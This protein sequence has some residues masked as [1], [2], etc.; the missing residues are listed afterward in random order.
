[1]HAYATTNAITG[2]A[3]A[4][5]SWN[6][7]YSPSTAEKTA[8]RD[9]KL[10][11]RL[12]SGSASAN[13]LYLV[14]DF[15]SATSIAGVAVLNHQLA[16]GGWTAPRITIEADTAGSFAT[17]VTA[18]AAT[19]LALTRHGLQ[20]KD[21]WLAFPAVSKRY[22]RLK[23]DEAGG[24]VDTRQVEIG[25]L[26]FV[27]SPT[28]LTRMETYGGRRDLEY[29][30]NEVKLD[31]G[32]VHST[33]RGG[34]LVTRRFSFAELK[35]TEKDEVLAMWH[36]TRGGTT[37]LLWAEENNSTASAASA[38]EQECVYGRLQRG[39]GMQLAD[40]SLYNPDGLQ[41]VSRGREMGA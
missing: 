21:T 19:T 20:V 7:A 39:F 16:A 35:P 6:H 10:A 36:A 37:N 27:A 18:K 23:F 11:P 15:G 8:L 25:E 5:F 1:M 9:G 26:L 38:A 24:G 41:L 22:W 28:S 17:A 31:N 29:F 33:F 3:A 13:P 4:A 34:P 32:D 30:V 40:H 12:T 2:L 14:I